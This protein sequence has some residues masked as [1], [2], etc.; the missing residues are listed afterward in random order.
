MH[1]SNARTALAL[2]LT[3]SLAACGGDEPEATAPA[4]VTPVA[5]KAP[6]A[7]TSTAPFATVALP[8]QIPPAVSAY[9]RGRESL[10][11][12]TSLHLELEY[13]SA[14]SATQY[15]TGGRNGTSYT[16][17]VRS[18]PQPD[19]VA[20]GSWVMHSGRH[21]QQVG[22][23]WNKEINTPGSI[24]VYLKAIGLLPLAESELEPAS[25]AVDNAGGATCQQR[26]VDLKKLP[27]TAKYFRKLG[28]CVDESAGLIVKL[29]GETVSGERF[30]ATISDYGKPV[31]VP[32]VNEQVKAWY[33]QYPRK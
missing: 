1:R 6:E 15:L 28:A 16:Y 9:E 17:N 4:D 25:G 10:T 26:S 8:P 14:A 12:V 30:V 2:S 24:V 33:D 19:R 22:E 11:S 7:T 13:T 27:A 23:I 29:D 5:A 32:Q 18:V 3:L 21:F 31:D 20:D